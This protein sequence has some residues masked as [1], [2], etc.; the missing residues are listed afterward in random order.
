MF[1]NASASDEVWAAMRLLP[2]TSRFR[3]YSA[4]QGEGLG[5]APTDAEQRR[6][7][8]PRDGSAFALVAARQA[9]PSGGEGGDAA[10][11]QG[12]RARVR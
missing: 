12:Q 9:P 11:E 1:S 6:F 10:A 5:E 7:G 8:F 2:A 3:L 4:W